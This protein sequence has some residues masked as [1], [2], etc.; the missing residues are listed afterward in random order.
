MDHESLPKFRSSRMKDRSTFLKNYSPVDSPKSLSPKVSS[1][2]PLFSSEKE[3][4]RLLRLSSSRVTNPSNMISPLYSSKSTPEFLS[5]KP[6]KEPKALLHF[7]FGHSPTGSP[8]PHYYSDLNINSIGSDDEGV[9]TLCP[10]Y[11]KS[12]S[13]FYFFH[14]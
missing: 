10:C 12:C 2:K 8:S 13:I 5:A 6:A 14:Y 3:P 4:E 11:W 1:P 7:Q 9:L